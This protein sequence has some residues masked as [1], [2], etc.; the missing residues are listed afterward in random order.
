MYCV[1]NRTNVNYTTNM[2]HTSFVR[3]ILKIIVT[4]SKL[5]HTE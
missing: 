5:G 3:L 2:K 1:Y 4:T